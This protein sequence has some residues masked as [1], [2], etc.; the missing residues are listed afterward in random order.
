LIK[1]LLVPLLAGAL[2]A[3]PNSAYSHFTQPGTPTFWAKAERAP[4]NIYF[5]YH[6]DAEAR[7]TGHSLLY[8]DR[9]RHTG[10]Q[11]PGLLW[12][13]L[14]EVSKHYGTFGPPLQL[15]FWHRLTICIVNIPGLDC[16]PVDEIILI[17][18]VECGT[19][20]IH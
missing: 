10:R 8:E 2:L 17:P 12:V 5:N 3:A 19:E 20:R 1:I 15:N 9:I 16:A 14:G 4:G 18:A 13:N 7:G 11:A 6:I